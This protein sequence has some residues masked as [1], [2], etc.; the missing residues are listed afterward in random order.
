MT[1]TRFCFQFNMKCRECN[2]CTHLTF[3]EL[4]NHQDVAW[5]IETRQAVEKAVRE[6]LP[7]NEFVNHARF[8]SFC[9]LQL[10]KNQDFVKKSV[11]DRLKLWA[12][13]LKN[14]LPVFI[15]GAKSF[16]H[17]RR[18]Q[19]EIR[20][21]GLFIFDADHLDCDP[22]I[23]Y[24]R[25]QTEGFAWKLMLAHKT[26]SGFGLRLVCEARPEVGN[27]A[28]NQI[29]L[30]KEL[31]LMGEIGSTGKPVVDNSCIDASRISF[32]PRR[33]DIYYMDSEG[34]FTSGSTEFAEKYEEQYRQGKT[35]PTNPNHHFD[36]ETPAPP[37]PDTSLQSVKQD[38]TPI[39]SSP[40]KGEA[41]GGSVLQN[42]NMPEL[43]GHPV[44]DYINV[45]L[46]NGAPV[47]CRHKEA[48]KLADD[49]VILL[50]TDREAAHRVLISLPWVQDVIRERGADEIKRI[51]DAAEKH[52]KKREEDNLYSPMPSKRMRKAIEQL[53][54][55]K[56][57]ALVAEQTQLPGGQADAE[58]YILQFTKNLGREIKKFFKYY[59]LLPLVCHGLQPK[60][61]AAGMFA[62][63]AF[64]M[65]LMTR[66]WYRFYAS[67]GKC[68][69][70]CLLEIIGPPGNGKRF[71]VELYKIMAEPIKKADAPQIEALNKWKEEQATK[72]ANRDKSACP[73]GVLRCLPAES[74]AAAIRDAMI[75]AKEEI[76]G[77]EWPLHVLHFNSELDNTITQMKKNAY[78][79][80][81]ALYLKAFHNEP[82]GSML[83][84]TTS[85]V[86]EYN[87]HLNC[88][89]S[90]TDYALNKQV[91]AENY[92]T[93]L[94]GRLTLVH[95][96][97]DYEMM[98]NQ[99]YTETDE[100]YNTLL[101]EWSYK[102]NKTYGEI[103]VK[104]LSDKLYEWTN[105]RMADAKE[106]NSKAELDLLKRCAWHGIN[107]AL[108]YIVSRH[109]SEMVEENGY[110]KPGVGFNLDSTDWKL[111]HLIVNA[112][113][114]FQRYFI[115]PIAEKFYDNK[116]I[117]EASNHRHQTHTK[118]AYTKL[119]EIFG[120]DD[121][122]RC[123]QYSGVSSGCSRLKRL[124][125]DGL[126]KKIRTGENKG[127]YQKLVMFFLVTLNQRGAVP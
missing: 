120:M 54:R 16:D 35:S 31:G 39:T 69:L 33:E 121:V 25:T 127:K 18:R 95:M 122:I 108:P 113:L 73:T 107:Y 42:A 101:R 86:G 50:D 37:Q 3:N 76:N 55:K 65:T 70:N 6:G 118:E 94:Y 7:V 22:H 67:P 58:E 17:N 47:N 53:T 103:P 116:A 82:H 124:Q 64:G 45:L 100:V 2:P 26:S 62:G 52:Y 8:K 79:D 106:D 49:L 10:R 105:N 72:G 117:T 97:A 9:N 27:I 87:V 14:N 93:G 41:E 71:L 34:L 24:I 46:P 48:L 114:T 104:M 60:H 13:S 36:G 125:D 28:D 66:M 4:I 51:M 57:T 23:I 40:H 80:F 99:E 88:V 32:C 30:A 98:Q 15:F 81:S 1:G 83:K 56:Y 92:S 21:S 11:N 19:D 112:Q 110:M 29:E 102:L 5:Q 12:T 59:P 20:L 38:S 115:G 90:G 68:R 78:M 84:T 109:W 123:Y 44:T 74:S 126:A 96:P 61:Y 111:C 63:G 119:P 85:K 77:E 75:N 43:F 89:Y 91:N